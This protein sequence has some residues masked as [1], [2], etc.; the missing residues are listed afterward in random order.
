MVAETV[1][2]SSQILIV[3]ETRKLSYLYSILLGYNST[4]YFNQYISMIRN[5]L[6]FLH[7]DMHMPLALVDL[8]VLGLIQVVNKYGKGY[9]YRYYLLYEI[10]VKDF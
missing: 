10:T 8:V 4:L 6:F 2:R 3:P 7:I 1:C 5:G 9:M